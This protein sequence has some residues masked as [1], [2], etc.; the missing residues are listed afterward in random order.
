MLVA[1]RPLLGFN[2]EIELHLEFSPDAYRVRIHDACGV[3][4]WEPRDREQA[5]DMFFH[6]F[7]FG[8]TTPDINLPDEEDAS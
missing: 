7:A 5:K 6:P 3:V 1:D 8:Y 2:A 4:E